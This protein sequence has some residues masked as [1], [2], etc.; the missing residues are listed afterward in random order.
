MFFPYSVGCLCTFL[1]T[2]IEEQDFLIFV[3]VQL[4]FLSLLI[5]AVAYLRIYEDLLLYFL[6]LDFYK[7]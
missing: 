6:L 1:M 2:F 3:E 5:L 4:I 7:F